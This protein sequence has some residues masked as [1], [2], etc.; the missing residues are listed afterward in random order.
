MM[1]SKYLQGLITAFAASLILVA[2]LNQDIFG[3]GKGHGGGNPHGGGG[4]P[5]QEKHQGGPPPGRGGGNGGGGGWQQRQ[6][7]QPQPQQVFRQQEYRMPPGQA[8]K[9]ERVYQQPAPQPQVWRQQQQQVWRQQQV[10]QQQIWRQQQQQQAR[11][12]YRMPPRQAKKIERQQQQQAYV[13][14]PVYQNPGRGNG[15][16]RGRG[17]REMIAPPWASG[18]FTPPG[19]L[20]SAEVHERNAIRKAE[21]QQ[22]VYQQPGYYQQPYS[23]PYAPSYQYSQP[24]YDRQYGYTQPYYDRQYSQQY[25]SAP[26]YPAYQY[27]AQQY[28]QPY[29]YQGGGY[30]GYSPLYV[31]NTYIYEPYTAYANYPDAYSYGSPYYADY[32]NGYDNGYGGS[33]WKSMLIRTLIGFV[34]GNQD[35]DYY[36]QQPYDPYYGYTAAGYNPDDYSSYAGYYPQSYSRT[37]YSQPVYDYSGY[38]APLV[39]F[40]PMDDLFGPSYG[41]YASDTLRQVVAQGYEQGYQAGWYARENQLRNNYLNSDYVVNDDYLDPYS[42][43]IGENRRCFTTGYSIGYQD[44]MNRRHDYISQDSGNT[45]LVSLLLSN[46]IG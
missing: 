25:Y 13:P 35:S 28:A 24:N 6:Q 12:S 26:V 11:Q 8:R 41:G 9:Q 32:G 37:V 5:G 33:N 21:R 3:Q 46:V 29:E 23:P 36:G 2:G 16:G 17:Q 34:L 27:Y 42:F 15:N 20:R 45:D 38:Q 40:L 19:Q 31:P 4:P 7:P 30:L 22:Q 43:S 10:P 18:G 39:N 14:A 1:R 44:A